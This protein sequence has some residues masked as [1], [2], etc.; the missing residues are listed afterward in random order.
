MNKTNA[1]YDLYATSNHDGKLGGGHY[2][3]YV[4][5]NGIWYEMDDSRETPLHGNLRTEDDS[6]AY[7]LFY[8][9]R[10]ININKKLYNPHIGNC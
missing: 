1:I 8:K 7:I 2:W 5:N 10:W 4:K 6:S 9:S 3:A